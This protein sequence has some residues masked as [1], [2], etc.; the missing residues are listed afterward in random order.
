MGGDLSA[1]LA[2]QPCNLLTLISLSV[3]EGSST[4]DDL[5]LIPIVA[6]TMTL[7]Q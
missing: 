1:G 7:Y 4:E 2:P 6:P 3:N 5:S